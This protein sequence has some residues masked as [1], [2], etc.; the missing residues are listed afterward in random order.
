[1][2]FSACDGL[3]LGKYD[4]KSDGFE[5]IISDIK[6]TVG[7]DGMIDE[8]TLSFDDKDPSKNTEVEV[9]TIDFQSKSDKKQLQRMTYTSYT[10]WGSIDPVEITV[11]GNAEEFSLDD[12]VNSI[13]LVNIDALKKVYEETLKIVGEDCDNPSF[14]LIQIEFEK[15]KDLVYSVSVKGNLKS[16]GVKK[17]FSLNFD[18]D[19]N[20]IK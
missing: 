7:D 18:K 15:D 20:L 17:S 2:L 8:I 12:E 19:G 5:R 3:G 14:S 6:K 9:A 13:S 16:N 10:G 4:I 1:M 11:R